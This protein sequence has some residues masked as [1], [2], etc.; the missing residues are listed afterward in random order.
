MK[1]GFEEWSDF[2]RDTAAG[3]VYKGKGN[4]VTDCVATAQ[5][6]FRSAPFNGRGSHAI[7]ERG[8][9]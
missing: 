8:R 9:S 1:H 3:M 6:R 2:L 7:H 5:I 4:E